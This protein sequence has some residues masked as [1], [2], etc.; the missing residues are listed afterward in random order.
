MKTLGIAGAL[1]ALTLIAACSSVPQT[2][3]TPGFDA[4]ATVFK[5][6]LR[7]SNGEF[8]LAGEQRQLRDALMRP[9][10]SGALPRGL[11]ETAG[12]LQGARVEIT[13]RAVAWSSRG[14][15]QVISHEGSQVSNQC[16]S[17]Y[18]ILAT[19]VKRVG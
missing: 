19:S 5:G 16:R 4:S 8:Q 3:P 7:V 10:T 9:C 18:V 13:G 12:D 11:Q 2:R 14:E 15:R 17:D 1:A 6:W